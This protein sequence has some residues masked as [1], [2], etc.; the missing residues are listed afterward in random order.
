MSHSY[1]R[2]VG[3]VF[4]GYGDDLNPVEWWKGLNQLAYTVGYYGFSAAGSAIWTG[5]IHIFTDWMTTDDPQTFGQSFGTVLMTVAPGIKKIPTPA[6]MTAAETS[7][8]TAVLTSSQAQ[9]LARSIASK[10]MSKQP[11]VQ[12][13]IERTVRARASRA[14]LQ[15]QVRPTSKEVQVFENPKRLTVTE[16]HLDHFASIFEKDHGHVNVIN[17]SFWQHVLPHEHTYEMPQAPV[18]QNANW[19]VRFDRKPGL[20]KSKKLFFPTKW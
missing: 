8:E 4:E 10:A 11:G 1:F 3:G 6:F 2:Q 20:L 14:G 18:G 15:I 16:E 12:A 9:A 19:R 5:T 7:A 17:K 13:A